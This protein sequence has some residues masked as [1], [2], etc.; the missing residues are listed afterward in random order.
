MTEK[1]FFRIR[2]SDKCSVAKKMV[3]G[4]I[5]TRQW[6]VKTGEVGNFAK[7]PDVEAQVVVKK[8]N[9][10]VPA[11]EGPGGAEAGADGSSANAG[12]TR[13]SLGAVRRPVRAILRKDRQTSRTLPA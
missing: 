3:N 2:L 12:G 5:L 11:E 4:L 10:F 13:R 6:Q 1:K 7:F 8:G 9:G